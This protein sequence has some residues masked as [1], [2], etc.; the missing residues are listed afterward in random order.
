MRL[1]SSW[2]VLS[3]A[4][5]ALG[6]AC[7]SLEFDADRDDPSG[8]AGPGNVADG[9]TSSTG[10]EP[11]P[12]NDATGASVGRV[13]VEPVQ[14]NLGEFGELPAVCGQL[15]KY[16]QT[17]TKHPLV[18]HAGTASAT[19]ARA[20]LRQGRR[21]E[22]GLLRLE[23]FRA[24]YL[25][26]PKLSEG[27]VMLHLR[28]AA[29]SGSPGGGEGGAG[30]EGGS[31]GT[32]GTGG[33][34]KPSEGGGGGDDPALPTGF[35][36][37][38]AL[39]LVARVDTPSVRTERLRVAL[40]VD[41]SPSMRDA[42]PV[43]RAVIDAVARG[44]DQSGDELAVLTYAGDVRVERALG[45]ATGLDDLAEGL[46]LGP[47]SGSALDAAIGAAVGLVPAGEPLHVVLVTDGATRLDEAV[48]E[49]VAQGHKGGAKLSVALV[50]KPARDPSAAATPPSFRRDFGDQLVS[51]GGGRLHAITNTTDADEVLG[52]PGFVRN[53]GSA[54][55]ADHLALELG[56]YF[57]VPVP[58]ATGSGQG[59]SVELAPARSYVIRL[60]A[61]VCSADVLQAQASALLTEV[62]ISLHGTG[63]AAP[64]FEAQPQSHGELGFDAV[65]W[66][67]L[68]V[69]ATVGVL[70]G[71]SPLVASNQILEASAALGCASSPQASGCD[72]LG[73]LEELVQLHASASLGS[74]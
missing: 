41:V 3:L 27:G 32:K 26:L 21:P 23:E 50:G 51:R 68:A 48:L 74:D 65:D 34:D 53:F 63:A 67:D 46:D 57:H 60:P 47:R 55:R 52:G 73:E 61:L 38:D 19:W 54:L 33:S 8:G 29:V 25:P 58:D 22:P 28:E 18:P 2:L 6:V 64:I 11:P 16:E 31:T 14:G 5:G 7:Q 40:L 15:P 39:E 59:S 37:W 20:M 36:G 42:L 17:S 35:E 10:L 66:V 62:S 24:F 45:S 70:R 4:L 44:L 1:R 30:G 56:P 43:T 12:E 72:A 9:S 69:T 13:E 49:R 71:G